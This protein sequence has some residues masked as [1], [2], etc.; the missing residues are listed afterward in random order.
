[1]LANP[2]GGFS[3]F[4][5]C[6][7]DEYPQL[8]T[9]PL[10]GC[11]P[12]YVFVEMECARMARYCCWFSGAVAAP[13]VYLWRRSKV[14]LQLRPTFPPMVDF[15]L[16]AI[17][18]ALPIG[19]L[20]GAVKA[21]V[22]LEGRY[23]MT[24]DGNADLVNDALLVRY[25]SELWRWTT[26]NGRAAT[27]LGAGFLVTWSADRWRLMK[28]SAGTGVGVMLASVIAHAEIDKFIDQV[29]TRV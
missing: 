4:R 28:Y 3:A 12:G 6:P 27:V 14:P 15:V 18:Y 21:A 24:K 16:P 9:V 7:I 1:M 20:L 26:I 17:G 10:M 2:L 13:S 5:V 29:T 25:D 19:L 8:L 22:E 11:Q 23:P